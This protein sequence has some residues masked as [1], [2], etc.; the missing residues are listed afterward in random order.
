MSKPVH[1]KLKDTVGK[2][3]RDVD[4]DSESLVIMFTDGTYT[5]A[6]IERSRYEEGS[7]WL[8][9]ERPTSQQILNER[10]VRI[11][12]F[13]ADTLAEERARIAAE[14]DAQ[15]RYRRRRTYEELHKEFGSVKGTVH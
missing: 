9:N 12:L 6:E 3:I 7:V 14:Q 4:Q 11:G 1:V 5:Y 8:S 2:T 10:G 15:A 13:T